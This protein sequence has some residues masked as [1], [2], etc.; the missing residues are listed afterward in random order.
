MQEK[1]QAGVKI[2]LNLMVAHRTTYVN[3]LLVHFLVVLK[4]MNTR[5]GNEP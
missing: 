2:N 5:K 1:K 3:I 4:N